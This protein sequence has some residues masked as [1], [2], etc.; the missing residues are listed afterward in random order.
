[1]TTGSIKRKRR[2]VKITVGRSEMWMVLKR[3]DLANT[4]LTERK[5]KKALLLTPLL[6]E[7]KK[8]ER[9]RTMTKMLKKEETIEGKMKSRTEE[10][11][12]QK[13]V[14]DI[15]R[16]EQMRDEK[17]VLLRNMR[18]ARRRRRKLKNW[19]GLKR[20]LKKKTSSKKLKNLVIS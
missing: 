3:K 19:K 8:T 11:N 4:T 20:G 10:K 7:E 16:R 2:K 9:K 13:K 1:M 17:R 14:I 5:A 15:G 18:G 6:I 12:L